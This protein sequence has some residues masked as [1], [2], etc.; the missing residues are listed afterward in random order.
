MKLTIYDCDGVLVNSEEIYL[1]AEL[2][3]LASIGASFE[4]KAYMQSF[5]RLSPGMWEA[6]L[7]N[8]VGAKT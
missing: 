1:A 5:M 2:E 3:F 8:C 4:R 7:Q 6:K